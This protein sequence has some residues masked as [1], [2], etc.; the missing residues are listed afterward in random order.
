M[1]TLKKLRLALDSQLRIAEAFEARM[2]RTVARA[3]AAERDRATSKLRLKDLRL[4][5][6][7]LR[8]AELETEVADLKEGTAYLHGRLTT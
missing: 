3:E 1:D 7:E 2:E 8:V 5:A 6:L 4:K